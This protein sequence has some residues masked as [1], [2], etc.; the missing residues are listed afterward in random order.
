MTSFMERESNYIDRILLNKRTI[1]GISEQRHV[2]QFVVL[3]YDVL[4]IVKT[5]RC[6]TV[7]Y[8]NLFMCM[9][10]SFVFLVFLSVTFIMI[11]EIISLSVYL[12]LLCLRRSTC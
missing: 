9:A 8:A 5:R 12:N 7:N 10:N 2:S 1:K 6:F 4:S 11:P 3:A